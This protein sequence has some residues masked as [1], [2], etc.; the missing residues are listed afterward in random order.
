MSKVGSIL[1]EFAKN[2]QELASSGLEAVENL[3][4]VA[5]EFQTQVSSSV[6]FELIGDLIAA[7]LS[8][9]V[10]SQAKQYINIASFFTM[11]IVI[12]VAILLGR[13]VINS[14]FATRDKEIEE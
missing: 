2:N 1:A 14:F 11:L 7:T 9:M 3:A 8:D 13:K 10:P 6:P 4:R 5:N 12:M